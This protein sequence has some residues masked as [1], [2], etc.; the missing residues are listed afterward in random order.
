MA[1]RR[2]NHFLAHVSGPLGDGLG[3]RMAAAFV[4]QGFRCLREVDL[5]P[6]DPSLPDIDLLV[7]SEEPTLGYVILVC[8]LKC[9]VPSQWAKDH[10]RALNDDGVSKA[11]RQCEKIAKFLTTER[12]LELILK[13]LPNGLPNFD[14]FVVVLEP[15]IITSHSGGMLFESESTPMFSYHTLER[16]LRASDGDIGYIQHMLRS[17]NGFVDANQRT[18]L[19]ETNLLTRQVAFEMIDPEVIIHFPPNQWRTSGHRDEH[20]REFIASGMQ[21]GASFAAAFASA[22]AAGTNSS[23]GAKTGGPFA[24]ASQGLQSADAAYRKVILF[25]SNDER[26]G[27]M[28]APVGDAAG[29]SPGQIADGG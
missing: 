2:S 29:Q 24:E 22:V 25:D 15:L 8:E 12:G 26:M 14:H 13:W 5:T 7:I 10:L 17:Y 21:P 6:F 18:Q 3:D 20:I 4:D 1:L 28:F 11:F 16:M 9:P 19:V 23:P 27:Q